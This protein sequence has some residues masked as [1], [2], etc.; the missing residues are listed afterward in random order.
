[1][2]KKHFILGSCLALACSAWFMFPISNWSKMHP[3]EK[4]RGVCWV[5]GRQEV[6]AKEFEAVKKNNINWI[7]QTPFAWQENPQSP[8]IRLNTESERVWWGESDQ[9]IKETTRLAKEAGIKTMLKPHLWIHHSWPGEIKMESDSLWQVW[10]EQYELF[11]LH[12]ARLA[13]E[14]NIEMLCIGTELHHA[15]SHEEEW[16]KLI[17]SIRA[18]YHGKITYAAN[19]TEEYEKIKFWD[20][21]DFIGV[22]AYFSLSK[23]LNPTV[24][25]MIANWATPLSSLEAIAGQYQRPV[26][27][28]EIGYRSTTD[29]AIEPWRWPQENLENSRSNETQAR[30]YEAFFKATW[31]KP[32]LGGVYFW[33]WYPH[34]AHRLGEI[35]FTP[36]GKP[37]EKVMSRYFN[38]HENN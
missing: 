9:G 3:M 12:Y 34:G 18:V 38:A 5:G 24:E 8:L 30:C 26:L 16:R 28:T 25:E 36:Q 22:Q 31:N 15:I 10:F 13:E 1:M 14:A 29:A 20:D 33:K 4:Q 35:D 2:K 6:T 37:A 27:F 17:E 7:S 23:N 32:W 19:F 21:L 11:I